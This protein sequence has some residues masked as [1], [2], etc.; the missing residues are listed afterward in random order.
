MVPRFTRRRRSGAEARRRA[1]ACVQ[2]LEAR[3]LLAGNFVISEFV[4]SNNGLGHVLIQSVGNLETTL[5]FAAVV[6]ISVFGIAIWYAAEWVEKISIPWHA[7][8]RVG[9]ATAV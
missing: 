2:S 5:A 7:S 6:V 8:Q 4:A 3:T 9:G 1:A